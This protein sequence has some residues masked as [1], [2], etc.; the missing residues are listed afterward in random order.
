MVAPVT[1][2]LS[3]DAASDPLFRPLMLPS[4]EICRLEV[5]S[6][7]SASP[8]EFCAVELP[9]STLEAAAEPVRLLW[10]SSE[11]T[12]PMLTSPRLAPSMLVIVVLAP[13]TPL[14]VAASE[15]MLLIAKPWRAPS[16]LMEVPKP[17]AA[18]PVTRP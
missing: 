4:E 5:A 3:A 16:E 12:P 17:E 14:V 7:P 9:P 8:R 6:K 13:A 15:E 18:S 11:P 1:P 10:P 2:V